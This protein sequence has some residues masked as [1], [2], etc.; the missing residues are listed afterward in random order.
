MTK[1]YHIFTNNHDDWTSDYK[2][3]LSIYND[4]KKEF[5]C[6]RLYEELWANPKTDD[7]FIEENCLKS[8]GEYPL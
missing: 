1:I 3:A 6:A 4:F 2:E 8:T 7:E 5:G